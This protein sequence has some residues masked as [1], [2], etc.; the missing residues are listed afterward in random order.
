M[1]KIER[2]GTRVNN[3]AMKDKGEKKAVAKNIAARIEE[4]KGGSKKGSP[5]GARKTGSGRRNKVVDLSRMP[6]IDD[7]IKSMGGRK[8]KR[9][10]EEEEPEPKKKMRT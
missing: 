3:V 1:E 5:G 10:L 8:S 9:K 7:F 6:R 4:L 2:V